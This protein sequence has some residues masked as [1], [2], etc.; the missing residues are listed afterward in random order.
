MCQVDDWVTCQGCSEKSPSDARYC[1]HCSRKL[2][3]VKDNRLWEGEVLRIASDVD[4]TLLE[5]ALRV[6]F[7]NLPN[8]RKEI[9]A[10]AVIDTL[11]F[12]TQKQEQV[13]I[14]AFNL[15]NKG[16]RARKD[17]AKEMGASTK[18]VWERVFWALG[19]LYD[20]LE[21]ADRE[22]ERVL[23]SLGHPLI[24]ALTSAA[25]V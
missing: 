5:E 24:V 10:M 6:R 19:A 11:P 23:S 8:N 22:T 21:K 7:G 14:R 20:G 4:L 3:Q 16:V 2:A 15:D 18:A 25:E 13:L 17:I 1:M 9:T 12:L